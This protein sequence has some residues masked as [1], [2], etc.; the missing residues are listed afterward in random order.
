MRGNTVRKQVFIYAGIT[1]ALAAAVA[2]WFVLTQLNV[3]KLFAEGD[4]VNVLL[5]GQD[6]SHVVDLISLIS[7]SEAD[8]VLFSFP[9]NLRLRNASG[10]FESVAEMCTTVGMAAAAEAIGKL[11]GLDIPFH[12]ACSHEMLESWIGSLGGL[13]ISLDTAAVYLDSTTD[14]AMRVEIRPGEQSFDGPGA[15]IFATAPSEPEDMGLLKRQQALLRALLDQGIAASTLRSLRSAI[16]ELAP[17]LETNLS[18]AD[19]QQVA[20]VLHEVPRRDCG[21]RRRIIHSAQRCGNGTS[22]C[23]IVEGS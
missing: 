23:R 5:V 8:A 15:M 17:A 22:C 19:L 21:D 12:I 7:F 18:L 2:M 20:E 9:S 6:P 16:R 10:A 3:D 14:P 4:R 13:A 1:L 11:I